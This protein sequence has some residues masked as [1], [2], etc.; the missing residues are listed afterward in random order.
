MSASHGL[1]NENYSVKDLA[2]ML[3][4]GALG[5]ARHLFPNGKLSGHEYVVGSINGEAG[6]SLSINV[7]AG[8]KAG[9]WKD[10]SAQVG[11]DLVDLWAHVRCRGDK[12]KAIMEVKKYLS[13]V[14]WRSR[15][16]SSVTPIRGKSLAGPTTDQH[17][18]EESDPL[19]LKNHRRLQAA[20]I[21]SQQAMAYLHGRGLSDTTI[22]HFGLGLADPYID[23]DG[24]THSSA[25]LAPMRSVETGVFL[26]KFHSTNIPGFTENPRADKG[27]MSGRPLTYWTDAKRGQHILFVCEG[28]KDVWMHWQELK[29]HGLTDRI[30]IM[31]STHGTGIPSEWNSEEFWKPWSA[32]YLAQ[33]NDDTG[34][35]LVETVRRLVGARDAYRA[36]V[37]LARGKDWNDYWLQGGTI[38]EFTQILD[39]AVV[40]SPR[41]TGTDQ[42]D[43]PQAGFTFQRPRIGL[44]TLAPVDIN[45]SFTNGFLYYPT[46]RLVV[47]ADPERPDGVICGSEQLVVRSDRTLHYCYMSKARPGLEPQFLLS[48]GTL[49]LKRPVASPKHSWSY[50]A[51]DDYLRGE[52]RTR[53]L[54]EIVGE[55]IE[56]LKATIWL[57]YEEDYVALAM[58][59]PATYVQAVFDAVPLLAM[60]GPPATGKTE[61]GNVMADLCC[62]GDVI[63]QVSAAGAAREIDATAGFIVFDDLEVIAGNT[64]KGE[65]S[66]TELLQMLKVSNKKKSAVKIWHNIKT[67]KQERLNLFGIKLFNNTQGIDSILNTRVISIPT[68]PVPEYLKDE[69]SDNSI[70]PDR[71]VS[72]R[73]EL[74]AW[75]FDHVRE[76]DSLYSAKHSNRQ[77]EI[78]EPLR[79]M[80]RM[81]GDPVLSGMLEACAGRQRRNQVSNSVDAPE[82]LLREAAE[83]LVQRG[84]EKFTIAHVQLEMRTLVDSN[85]GKRSTTE[86]PEWDDSRWLGKTLRTLDL[87]EPESDP[88]E[89]QMIF[90]T[91][92]R[93]KQFKR[94][95]LDEVRAKAE[96][97]GMKI[98][99]GKKPQ[100]FCPGC[101]NCQYRNAGCPVMAGRRDFEQKKMPARVQ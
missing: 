34:R 53:A 8:R 72:L 56:V 37:P 63:G 92:L 101:Q 97:Q 88:P 78:M 5:V 96:N 20:L 66:F 26:K 68:R 33:D 6:K 77:D 86:I 75:A 19:N 47:E 38:E 30:M 90:G 9:V 46:A 50:A 67:G 23:Q 39:R 89:R 87:I 55:V 4:R 12:R 21:G 44:F 45:N 22:A 2:R 99:A 35:R 14:D 81:V 40:V 32:I 48:D 74:H 84:F 80:A 93:I 64:K 11:G 83:N 43:V 10:F 13:V 29:R 31:T 91:N 57:P 24:V 7:G 1:S 27:W 100:D 85:W 52:Q 49:V 58:T 59:V 79:V 65:M 61:T 28:E 42:P 18:G 98:V 95:F 51:I 82:A 69:Y 3:A 60:V 94:W 62:N 15:V 71:L 41:P 17:Q 54:A 76:V 73:H 25:L 36:E 16:P 70:D